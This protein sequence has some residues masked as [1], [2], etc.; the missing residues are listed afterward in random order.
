[1]A[2]KIKTKSGLEDFELEFTD[3]KVTEV[4]Q[5]NPF[6][7]DLPKRLFEAQKSIEEKT[8][9]IKQFELDENGIPNV[10]ECVDYLESIN[11]I[12]YD[13]IDYAYGNKISDT[14]FKYCSPFAVIDGEYYIWRFMQQMA[15]VLEP[16]IG[17]TR[18]KANANLNKHIA[19]YVKK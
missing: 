10:D 2:Y 14:V 9:E 6:D 4:I 3:R 19:K 16:I 5:F 17:E 15:E 8:K 13:A 7:T 18:K 12:V 1:M 11:K